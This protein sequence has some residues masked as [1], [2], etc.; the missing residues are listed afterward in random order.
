M[1]RANRKRLTPKQR[2]EM[3]QA[4]GGLCG[5]G[6]GMALNYRGKG[7]TGEHVWWFVSLGNDKLPDA[8]Y[9]RECALKKTNG[10][11]GDINTI[12]HVKRLR[13]GRTQHDRRN[14]RGPKLVSNTKLQSPGFP[15]HITK[16][17]NGKVVPRGR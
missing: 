17:M 10:P 2:A 1:K 9:R 14:E 16:T 6:C 8:L 13:D 15:T 12:A 3:W 7:D 5:C 4:Q 11:R